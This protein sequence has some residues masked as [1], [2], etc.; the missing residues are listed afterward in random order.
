M[1]RGYNRTFLTDEQ[2]G[3]TVMGLLWFIVLVGITGLAVDVTDGLRS[4]TMLQATA[5][6]AALAAVI[7]LPDE[8]AAIATAVAYADSNMAEDD[9]GTVLIEADVDVGSW[10]HATHIFTSGAIAPDAVRV[11]TRR[12]FENQNALPVN[13]L[14]IIGLSN[15]N[16]TTY[17]IAQ[18]FIPD[19]LTD[20]LLARG[21]VDISS[22]NSF[23]NDMC[24][25]GQQGVQMAMNNQFDPGV[26]VTM[27]DV[28]NDLVTP[29]GGTSGNPGL[30]DALGEESLDPR[31]VNHVDNIMDDLLAMQD[32]VTPSYID[33][34]L[35]V[36]VVNQTYNFAG[37][38]AGRVYHVEC[39][40]NKNVG[41]PTNTVLDRVVIVADCRI[42]V[43]PRVAMSDVVLA[44]RAGGNPGNPNSNTNNGQGGQGGA[45]VESA[46][47]NFSANV[48]L[49][50]AD[51]CQPGGGVQVFS[52]ASIHFASTTEYN[53]VQIVATG[54]VDLGARGNGINGINVQTGGDIT[55]TSNDAFGLCA[56]GAPSLFTVDYY[57]LVF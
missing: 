49:G 29:A 1:L 19:C 53:G 56:G 3:G 55:M 47:I 43:G 34:T 5:D 11:R 32:Y 10:D 24:V 37:V 22:N 44:S 21:V 2:G 15:W 38:E 17:A 16:V 31:M 46:N 54:D 27:P 28:D 9:Y 26:R 20:G 39:A 8:T 6:A 18:R 52:N 51:G 41:I 48:V 35:D 45:G 36:I 33:T 14:R 40:S 57:R 25:H 42:G 7:D 50:T 23:A 4:R 13:F 12:S 30:A